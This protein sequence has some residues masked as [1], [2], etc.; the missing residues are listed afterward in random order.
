MIIELLNYEKKDDS[1]ALFKIDGNYSSNKKMLIKS[2]FFTENKNQMKLKNLLLD[3][4]FNVQ[5][6]EKV[7]LHFYDKD[8]LKINLI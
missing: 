8:D 2:I 3:K 4:Y 1:Q 7:Q 5:K 6:F